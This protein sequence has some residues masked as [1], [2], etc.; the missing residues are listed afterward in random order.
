MHWPRIHIRIC[1]LSVSGL[2]LH[3]CLLLKYTS[4][5]LEGWWIDLPWPMR[6][7]PLNRRLFPRSS[8]RRSVWKTNTTQMKH[9][10]SNWVE[11]TWKQALLVHSKKTTCA[12]L[13]HEPVT[14][15][16]AQNGQHKFQKLYT[17]DHTD[18]GTNSSSNTHKKE[19]KPL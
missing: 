17:D 4:L 13:F 14:A 7:L 6:S 2:R 8:G 15:V 5:R 12:L 11:A 3:L 9:S 10:M 16:R 19:H 1:V 18:L